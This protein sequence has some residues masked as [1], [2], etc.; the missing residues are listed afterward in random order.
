MVVVRLLGRVCPAVSFES[1]TGWMGGQGGPKQEIYLQTQV[2][3]VDRHRSF[4]SWAYL[5]GCLM[6]AVGFPQGEQ[7]T[8]NKLEVIVF[9]LCNLGSDIRSLLPYSIH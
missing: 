9:L 3:V 4:T 5:Q 6:T 8:I 1:L 2:V 7:E